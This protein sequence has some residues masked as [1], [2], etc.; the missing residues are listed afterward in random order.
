[1][2]IQYVYNHTHRHTFSYI[3]II[4]S[5]GKTI[6]INVNATLFFSLWTYLSQS[7]WTFWMQRWRTA[8]KRRWAA[9]CR[10]Q[11]SF[12]IFRLYPLLSFLETLMK[13]VTARSWAAMS[14][15]E[16][17]ATLWSSMWQ[18]SHQHTLVNVLAM[19]LFRFADKW[20]MGALA[21]CRSEPFWSPL[22]RWVF[23][24]R[25]GVT[26]TLCIDC[27]YTFA[28]AAVLLSLLFTY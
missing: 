19:W 20:L 7:H 10:R 11:Q 1:M 8:T 28:I 27:I 26:D 12:I 22:M 14:V 24:F 4:L 6:C 2:Y 18:R 3:T 16:P 9:Y 23:F 21:K 25:R 13:V 17:P 5:S 15:W